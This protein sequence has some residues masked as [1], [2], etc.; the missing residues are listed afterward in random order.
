MTDLDTAFTII[1]II[2][3]LRRAWWRPRDVVSFRDLAEIRV[4]QLRWWSQCRELRGDLY[5]F[6]QSVGTT[7]GESG[8]RLTRSLT[9]PSLFSMTAAEKSRP[10]LC[11]KMSRRT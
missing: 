3:V 6:R 4:D 7:V 11:I 2:A 1:V 9:Q 5:S 10:Y 8:N